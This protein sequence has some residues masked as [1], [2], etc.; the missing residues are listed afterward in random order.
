MS[1][2][3]S[4]RYYWIKLKTSLLTS[5]EVDFLMRQE[6]GS[7]YVVLYQCLCLKLANN[8]GVLAVLLGKDTYVPYTIEKIAGETKGWFSLDTIRVAME[9]FRKLGLVVERPD[10]F[11]EIANFED[12]VGSETRGAEYKRLKAAE[13][14]GKKE[15]RNFLP[16]ID[17]EK[18]KERDIELDTELEKEI[19]ELNN[20]KETL[21]KSEPKDDDCE[22]AKPKTPKGCDPLIVKLC[23]IGY[24]EEHEIPAYA[25]VITR[26]KDKPRIAVE[27]AFHRFTEHL[28][29][30][31]ENMYMGFPYFDN[32]IK[33]VLE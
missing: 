17:K 26:Y 1:K 5:E 23:E 29:L 30:H 2:R 31:P 15:G 8:N 20:E 33:E 28:R 27:V 16:Y 22:P 6:G 9:L 10:G 25:G 18:D 14:K 21:K 7:N 13:E 19:N 24:I 4:D 12:L 11:W 3:Q 32:F